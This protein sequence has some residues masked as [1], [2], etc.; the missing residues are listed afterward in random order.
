MK[1]ELYKTQISK[2]LK[3]NSN[4]TERED[5]CGLISAKKQIFNTN[6]ISDKNLF[7]NNFK[8]KQI[9]LLVKFYAI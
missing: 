8:I 6:D 1:K 9:L 2:P 4:W 3:R 5:Q 7:S